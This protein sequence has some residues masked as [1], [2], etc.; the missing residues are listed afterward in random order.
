MYTP[1]PHLDDASVRQ[2]LALA[3]GTNILSVDLDEL[4]KRLT[5]HPWVARAKVVRVLPDTLDVAVV[6]H[7]PSAVLLADE[8][9]LLDGT[10]V[11]FKRLDDGE[12]GDLPI[13]TGF[14][15]RGLLEDSARTRSRIRRGLDALE[16]YRTKSRPRL[17]EINVDDEGEVTLYTAEAGSQLKLGRGSIA[18]ALVRFDALRAALGEE[19]DRVAVAHLDHATAP[20]TP[21]RVVASFL[22][23][24]QPPAFLV[25]AGQR[26][27]DKHAMAETRARAE[28]EP[29]HKRRRD[30]RLPRYE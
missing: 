30:A 10:G 24:E 26:A 7:V 21:D 27:V 11:P 18:P 29:L 8:L 1:T 6:E 12:R 9:Y 17:S 25:E 22:V 14:E 5:E 16:A 3:P 4:A 15:K 23:A 2:S 13:L 20:G 19:S 28:V